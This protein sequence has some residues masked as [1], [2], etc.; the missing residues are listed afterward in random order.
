MIAVEEFAESGGLHAT[1]YDRQEC[2]IGLVHLGYGAFHRAHQAVYI[3]D[4]M[5]LSGD[6]RW[7]IAAINL[8]PSETAAF[9][10]TQSVENGYLL[11]TT[12]P[13]GQREMR[14]VRPHCLFLDW[15]QQSSE[16]EDILTRTSVHTVTITV[17]E[18]GYYLKDDWTLNVDDPVIAAEISGAEAS[19]V[20]AFL[21]RSLK[22]RM[23][24]IDQPINILCCDNIRS[25]GHIL[26]SNLLAY[27]HHIGA[28]EL[29]NWVKQNTSFPCSMVDRIT[30]RAT[31]DLEHEIADLFP[32]QH[33]SPVH[34]ES[35]IQWVLENKFCAPMPDL[36][37][38]G[39][40]IV[41]NVDPFEETKI[42]ILN[43]GHTALC[44]LGALAGHST[45]D[46]AFADP[47]LRAVFNSFQTEE[48]LPGLDMK[49]PFE[50]HDY[51]AQIASRFSNKAIADQLE[52]I[53]MDGYSKMPV[54]IRPTL[55]SCLRQGILPKAAMFCIAGWYVYAR[56]F[57]A[58][59]MPVHYNEPYWDQLSP[60]LAEGQEETFSRTKQLWGDVPESY[61][62]FVSGLV[63]AIE[64]VES[65]WPA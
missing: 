6:L 57:A 44:Y 30:P 43:G 46:A 42:R 53:C 49:L 34:G 7:G 54:F 62:E 2:Q 58:G 63:S 3:D 59:Q 14:L 39:V 23:E 19:S 36:S 64:E 55:S 56:R 4:Y 17:T 21:A 38:S 65:K 52:R 12:S 48:V 37:V 45:Y 33:L 47:T 60:L 35:Y 24:A 13:D 61:P 51:L 28:D 22:R 27:L 8:R 1:K 50:K 26:E 11:K 9:Q 32:G 25:N 20:Y 41:E 29:L 16:S 18:S 5:D 40:E 31:D 10:S 15:S